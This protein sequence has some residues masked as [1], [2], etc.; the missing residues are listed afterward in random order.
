MIS[1]LFN[2]GNVL[3]PS[4]ESAVFLSATQWPSVLLN[5]KK[6]MNFVIRSWAFLLRTDHGARTVV[7]TSSVMA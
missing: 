2:I 4:P 5:K 3:F 7:R 1:C 6:F